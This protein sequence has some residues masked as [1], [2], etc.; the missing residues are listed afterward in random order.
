MVVPDNF[1]Q[2]GGEDPDLFHIAT[3]GRLIENNE[4]SLRNSV[5]DIYISKQRTITNTGRLLEEYMTDHE[6]ARF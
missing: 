6:K 4:D 3:I 5:Q 2:P 1:G